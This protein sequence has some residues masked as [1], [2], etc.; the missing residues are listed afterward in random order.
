MRRWAMLFT[1]LAVAACGGPRA[2]VTGEDVVYLDV[3][4]PEEYAEG[5]VQGA[6]LIPV[7][8]IEQRVA[9]LEPYRDRPMVVYCRTGRRSGIA[10]QVLKARGF[11]RAE[12]GGA[13]S[14]LAGRG[15]PT[16]T[17]LPPAG[18]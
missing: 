3:R 11:D 9:E 13:F 14:G 2:E 10:L 4:T 8:E 6:I 16:A 12:N 5:H 7:D 15:V 17:G 18:T 1:L